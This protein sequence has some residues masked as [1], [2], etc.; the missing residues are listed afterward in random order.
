MTNSPDEHPGDEVPPETPSA[1]E[2]SCPDCGGTGRVGGNECP[3]C[4]GD[5]LITEAVGGG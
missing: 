4:G 5:G 3:T 1:G 2:N